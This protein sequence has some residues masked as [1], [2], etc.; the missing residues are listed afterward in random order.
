[1]AELHNDDCFNI[2]PTI[3]NGSVD[4]VCVDLPYGQTANKW[5]SII[6][7][8]KMWGELKRCCKDNC[9]YIFFTTTKFGYKLIQ[10]NEKWFR[11]DVVM[12]KCMSGGFLNANKQPLRKHELFYVFYKKTGTYNPQKTDGKPYT[13]PPSHKKTNYG[14]YDTDGINNKDGKRFPIS[15]LKAKQVHPRC[16]PTQ[17]PLDILEWIV[18][19]YSNEGE[20]VLDFTM[21]SGSCGVA[22]TKLNRKFIG[23]EMDKDYFDVAVERINN[24]GIE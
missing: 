11:Y 15:I 13:K 9:I 10:S 22:C 19:T 6:D 14:D 7:M 5:D 8:D 4:M 23:V 2:L 16:H 3:E 17:K 24:V 1:M 21:G 20:V 12:E 18:K